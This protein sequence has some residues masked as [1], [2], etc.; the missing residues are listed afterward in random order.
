M[1]TTTQNYSDPVNFCE[2]TERSA[3]PAGSE[4]YYGVGHGQGAQEQHHQQ[5]G[6]VEI[7][8]PVK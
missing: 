1:I 8:R 3:V 2:F 6:E 7:V 4:P 5:Q